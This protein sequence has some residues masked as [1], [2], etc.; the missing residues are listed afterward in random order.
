M[1]A[2]EF[3]TEFGAT[4][5]EPA[6]F[7]DVLGERLVI[8][9]AM[10]TTSRTGEIKADK[11]GRGQ[12]MKLLASA[13][14]EPDEIWVRLEWH[15]A[16]KKTVVRRRYVTRLQLPGSDV[17]TLAVF[18]MGDDGWS[19]VTAFVNEFGDLDDLRIGVR[20]YRREE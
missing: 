7:S 1:R 9:K 12:Y 4:L 2:T 17:P 8:G 16:Q 18:E 6:V 10:F 14:K 5:D 19:G 13:L 20:L 15:F 11:N 3:L